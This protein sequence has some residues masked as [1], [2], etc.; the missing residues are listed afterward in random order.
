MT[1]KTKAKGRTTADPLAGLE[2][3]FLQL[4]DEYY[5]GTPLSGLNVAQK[6]ALRRIAGQTG[7][8]AETFLG[9]VVREWAQISGAIKRDDETAQWRVPVPS[10]S[11]VARHFDAV[12]AWMA[13]A[14][15][16]NIADAPSSKA[17]RAVKFDPPLG[18][19][20]DED[21]EDDDV[22]IIG[23]DGSDN[24]AAAA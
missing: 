8:A 9:L 16:G 11:A 5:P 3:T 4:M 15:Y 19:G 1:K 6:D 21:D 12:T 14:G 18:Y 13:S 17:R 22:V 20:A 24:E 10:L 23:G 2:F 7:K